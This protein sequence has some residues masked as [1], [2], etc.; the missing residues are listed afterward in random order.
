MSIAKKKIFLT[1]GAGFIGQNILENFGKKYEFLSPPKEEL[2]L[3]K[4]ADVF[5]YLE[6]N[7]LD[8]VIHL[9]SIGGFG[10]EKK[11]GQGSILAGNLQIFF[12]LIRANKFYGRMIFFG[13]GA[14]YDKKR[15]LKKVKETDFGLSIPSDEYSLYKYICS[16]YIENHK[17][18]V[19][20]RPFAVY[21]KYE[22][23]SKFI[24]DSIAKNLSGKDIVI[25]QN[26]AYH[27][28]F[29]DDLMSIL[30]YFIKNKPKF[31]NYNVT[32]DKSIDLIGICDIINK[33]SEHKSKIVVLKEG[34]NNEYTGDNSRLKK[35]IKGLKFTGYEQGI[36]KLF[37]YYK[38][39]L[40]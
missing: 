8:L 26:V 1:G 29:I 32:P 33:I 13:S 22:G 19:C 30:D 11:E 9:A 37:E 6:K 24:S 2:D 12:N 7:R 23:H 31:R 38:K 40:N 35:E 10:R 18:V 14:E 25:K 21:G 15:E 34:M 20:L 17:D 39:I 28:L 3:M 5:K 16:E 4:E 27:H 36:K